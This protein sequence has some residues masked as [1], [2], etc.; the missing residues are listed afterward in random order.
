MTITEMKVVKGTGQTL[1][2]VAYTVLFAAITFYSLCPDEK[3]RHLA[4]VK[5]KV[6]RVRHWVEV[7][8]TLQEIQELPKTRS[9]M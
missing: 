4:I 7:Q 8:Q 9:R 3:D 5:D 2:E 6:A 1:A